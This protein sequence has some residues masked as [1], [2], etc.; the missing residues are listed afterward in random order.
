MK[1][2]RF[3]IIVPVYNIEDYIDKCID[4]ILLQDYDNYEVII[5]ND[6]SKDNSLKKLKKYEK[7]QKV[8]IVT[9]ENGGLS[10]ARNYG[11][12]YANGEYV[13]FVDGDD[14]IE[15]GSL[16]DLN[17]RLNEL[18][19]NPELL[20]FQYYE[21]YQNK[22]VRFVDRIS[23]DKKE[24]L[25]LVA[26]SAWSKIYKMEYIKKENI[27]FAEGLIYEDLEINPFLLCTASSVEFL[28]KPLYNYVIRSGSIMN[29]KKFKPN[30]D[31]KFVVLERLFNRFKENKIYEKYHE[32]LTYLAIRHLIMVYSREIMIF[33]KSIYLP[34]CLRV[35][36]FLNEIDNN[37]I[38][39]K[40][41]KESSK[42]S[43]LFAK[44]YKKKMFRTCKL[45]IR[46]WGLTHEN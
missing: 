41:L 29:E 15:N 35:L 11:L 5:V 32:Q 37:W 46:I 7:N 9:K 43:Q 6:G 40:Y 36:E 24:Y 8:R 42:F 33:D 17:E 31:D 28:K 39:N 14:Y 1:K 18:D 23:W 27:K 10:S 20:V 45:I 13:W 19:S 4:S 2:Y 44:F 26:V 12:K 25:P 21:D 16:N 30:R 34:R 38:N 22:R 3:S